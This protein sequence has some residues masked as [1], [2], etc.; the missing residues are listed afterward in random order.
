MT[1]VYHIRKRPELMGLNNK[2]RINKRQY[3]HT[4]GHHLLLFSLSVVSN[5]L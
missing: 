4:V 1:Q 5:S 3:I 2:F